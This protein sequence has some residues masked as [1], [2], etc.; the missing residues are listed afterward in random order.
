MKEGENVT[1]N[2]VEQIENMMKIRRKEVVVQDDGKSYT[3]G[4][5]DS[6]TYKIASFLQCK[7]VVIEDV[8]AICVERSW[9]SVCTTVGILRAGAAFLPIDKKTPVNRI[10]KILKTSKA[11]MIICDKDLVIDSNES[12][13]V[14][15]INQI[16]VTECGGNILKE[17][18]INVNTLAYVIFT[19]GT[20]GEPKGA[21]IEHGG[22]FNHVF[23]KIS[24]L[25]LNE[26]SVVAH[27]ASIGFDI[28]VWQILAPLC[29]GAK[30]VIFPE[31]I[32]LQISKF[33]KKIEEQGI[34]VLE[35]V[36]MYLNI[37]I[38]EYKRSGKKN[39]LKYVISTGQEL[40]K[41]TV[42]RWFS[43]FPNIP[44]INAY[45]PTEAS[46]DIAHCIITKE[47]KYDHIPIGLPINN[48]KFDIKYDNNSCNK[49][50][51]WVS[52]ICVGRGYIGNEEET[53]KN[54][55]I[56][57]ETGERIYKTGDLVSK[58]ADGNYF[59][60]GRIDNQI[61]LHGNRI[62]IGEIENCIMKFSC[63]SGVAV[64]YNKEMEELCAVFT[65]DQIVDLEQL[66]AYLKERMPNYM[67]PSFLLQV[68]KI[69][70]DINGKTDIREISKIAGCNKKNS[71]KQDENTVC[72]MIRK[73]VGEQ[74]LPEGEEWKNDLKSIGLDSLQV[75]EL[76]VSIEETFGFEF[77]EQYLQPEVLFNFHE[78][79]KCV[80]MQK[81][82]TELD[83]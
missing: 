49:G 50:E 67:I 47:D 48:A 71:N 20:T 54:F 13:D 15:N 6:I 33:V 81:I 61:K 32:I 57:K 36:P 25:E 72:E 22:M 14:V 83:M 9:L 1:K 77:D 31:K 7:G 40:T 45:G 4:D 8:V 16:I 58:S 18:P 21:M 43:V 69:P 30:I 2:I 35:V 65:A 42:E 68:S 73:I 79:C 5:L 78:I 55:D 44:L 19:S 80:Q 26:Q 3:Y 41:A 63:V 46:D 27:N 11:K 23:E 37:I 59:Y 28:S 29:C 39:S 75:I 82:K 51:L 76:I 34:T 70:V 66:K 64:I 62:E 12:L 10:K 56:N 53:K 38:N 52:G 17:N 74:E 24:L 60:H